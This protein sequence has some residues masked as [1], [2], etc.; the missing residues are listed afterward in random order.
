MSAAEARRDPRVE[1]RLMVR[2]RAA[3]GSATSWMMAPLR[4]LSSSGARFLSDQPFDPGAVLELQ[5]VLPASPQAVPMQ[6]RVAW[7]KPGP[8]NLVE[9][10]VLFEE[11]DERAQDMLGT[12]VA[13]FL[14]RTKKP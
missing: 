1:R 5:L 4:D 11:V 12:A 10:G 3:T 2:F 6:A 9:L 14:K 13:H 8:L 7:S